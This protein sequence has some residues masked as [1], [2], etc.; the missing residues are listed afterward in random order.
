[1]S[2]YSDAYLRQT[3]EHIV[4]AADDA[5]E[6]LRRHSPPSGVTVDA[7]IWR[8]G[9]IRR[10]IGRCL[11]EMAR[12]DNSGFGEVLEGV[13]PTQAGV[14]PRPAHNEEAA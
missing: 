14:G 7:V 6:V 1:M 11:D 13:E 8:L 12:N 3:F 10:A 5:E 2:I 9:V 4:E